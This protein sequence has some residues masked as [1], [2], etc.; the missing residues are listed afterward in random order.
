MTTEQL[1]ELKHIALE[2][3]REA[4][5]AM[6][7]YAKECDGIERMEAFEAYGKIRTATRVRG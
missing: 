5:K 3:H 2:K 4:E 7:A 6:Y 1:A